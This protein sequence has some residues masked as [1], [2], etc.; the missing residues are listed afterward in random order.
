VGKKKASAVKNMGRQTKKR[1]PGAAG[2]GAG[3]A[4]PEEARAQ[5]A[6]Q[7]ARGVRA[8][9]WAML[10]SAVLGTVKVVTGVVGHSYALVADGVESML[11]IGSSLLVWGSLKVAATDPSKRFPYGYGKVEALAGLVIAAALLV[12]A[13]GL[14]VQSVWEILQPHESPAWYT[15]VVLIAVVATKELLSRSLLRTG[16]AIKSRAVESDAWH[17][18]SDAATSLAAAIGIAIALWGGRGWESADDWAALVACGLIAFNGF[19]QLR[20]ALAEVLDAAPDD[21]LIQKI[22]RVAKKVEGVAAIEKVRARKSGLGWLVDIH[23][24]VDGDLAVR[25]GHR[26]AHEVQETLLGADIGVL[27]ALVHI[28]PAGGP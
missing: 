14:A 15:L 6:R 24:E 26:L 22:R 18:R 2:G 16:E 9:K 1:A 25:E 17:H 10:V 5:A 19:V 11:D 12:A 7:A 20:G 4:T 27:D 28:E 8:A 3:S 21:E 13:V 23:V